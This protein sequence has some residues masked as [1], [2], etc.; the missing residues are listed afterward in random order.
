MTRLMG[1]RCP[2][3]LVAEAQRLCK[4]QKNELLLI[5]LSKLAVVQHLEMVDLA[6][7][8]RVRNPAPPRTPLVDAPPASSRKDG[9]STGSDDALER[10]QPARNPQSSLHRAPT[11]FSDL[12]SFAVECSL[13]PFHG[14]RRTWTLSWPRPAVMESLCS[15]FCRKRL[16]ASAVLSILQPSL[17]DADGCA[18]TWY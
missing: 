4:N 7:S 10:G 18:T 8:N 2:A 14:R 17:P 5:S 1:R 11:C 15:R 13:P 3:I 16:R 9:A 6:R 12:I